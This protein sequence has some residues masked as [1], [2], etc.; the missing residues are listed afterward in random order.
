MFFYEDWRSGPGYRFIANDVENDEEG[1]GDHCNR[2]GT[3][4]LPQA[5]N[6]SVYL[7]SCDDCGEPSLHLIKHL[8]SDEDATSVLEQ[9]HSHIAECMPFK[10]TGFTAGYKE[11]GNYPPPIEVTDL[12][13]LALDRE[14]FEYN[15]PTVA[16]IV[17]QTGEIM[18]HLSICPPA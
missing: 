18:K 7:V 8:S 15:K 11:K 1:G 3:F 6:Q 17:N 4:T 9:L 14:Q 10:T 2:Y 12:A 16:L 5:A 13:V